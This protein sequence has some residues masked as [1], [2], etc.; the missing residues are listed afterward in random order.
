M[1]SSLHEIKRRKMTAF[2]LLIDFDSVPIPFLI[3][4]LHNNGVGG[5]FLELIHSFLTNRSVQLKVNG[6][7]G[8]IRKC[9]LI[10]LP[11]GA[12]LSPLL[13]IIYIADLLG[14]KNLPPHISEFT[15]CYKYADDGSVSVIASSPTNCLSNMQKVCDYIHSWCK[16]WR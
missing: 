13:F 3:I 5:K 7:I 16:L 14:S 4:K 8:P 10:G 15:K 1:L 6:F 11:Q 12:V 9:R 2:I